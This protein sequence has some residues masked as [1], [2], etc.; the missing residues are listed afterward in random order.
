MLTPLRRPRLCTNYI[1][2][3]NKMSKKSSTGLAGDW[4][5]S[6]RGGAEGDCLVASQWKIKAPL[7]ILVIL[8]IFVIL[9]ILVASQ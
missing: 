5:R 7:L 9:V 8:V 3:K 6:I 2:A 1:K 4:Q